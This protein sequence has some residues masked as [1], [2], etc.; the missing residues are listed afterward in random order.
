M[1]SKGSSKTDHSLEYTL[2]F[3][4]IVLSKSEAFQQVAL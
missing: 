4:S 3:N 1:T 2:A